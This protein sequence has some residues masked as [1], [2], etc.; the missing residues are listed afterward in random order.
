MLS[1]ALALPAAIGLGLAIIS[2]AAWLAW[3]S[4]TGMT[5]AAV[6]TVLAGASAVGA[7]IVW[8]KHAVPMERPGRFEIGA[9]A[10]AA[11]ATGLAFWS[12]PWLNPSADSFYHMAAARSLLLEGRALP[13]DIFFGVAVPYPDPTSGSLH[14]V[15]AWLSLAGGMVPAWVALCLLGAALT[16]LSFAAF[17]REVTLSVPAALIATGLYLLIGLNLDMRNAGYPAA[18]GLDLTWLTL[19]FLLRFARSDARHRPD[20]AVVCLLG[21]TSGSVYSGVSL[22]LLV[23][24]VGTLGIA[25]VVAV[26]SR[27]LSSIR[28]LAIACLALMIAVVPVL[29]IRALPTLPSP[30]PGTILA[31][32]AVLLKVDAFHGYPFVHPSFWF[33]GLITMTTIGT[34]CL[35]GRARR[36]LLDGD[37]GA[38]LI[39][40]GLLFVPAGAITPLVADTS[41]GLYFFA[42]IALLL[43]ALVFVTVGWE[44]SAIF[45]LVATIRRRS[46]TTPAA[47][48][49]AAALL[50]VSASVFAISRDL[51]GGALARY[52]GNGRLSITSSRQEDLTAQWADRLKALDTAGP[53]TILADVESSYELAG[54][55]GRRIVGVAYGHTPYQDL[56]RDGTL[57]PRDVADALKPAADP[58]ALL[59]VLVRYRVTFVMVDVDRLGPTASDWIA[60]QKA[61][62]AVAG[63]R[64]WELYRFDSGRLDQALDIPLK[65]GAGIFP[66]RV[67]AGRAIFARVAS[68]GEAGV[69]H[70][71]AVG[72]TSGARYQTQF[73][74]SGDAGATT[75]AALLVPDSVPVDRY[76]I[77]VILPGGAAIPDGEVAVG[78]AYEAE[79][80]SGVVWGPGFPR[81]RGW[82]AVVNPAYEGGEAAHETQAGSVASRPLTDPPG[83]YCLSVVVAGNGAAN[84]VDVG[85]GGT[86]LTATWPGESSGI[87]DLEIATRVG[88]A[89]RQLAYWV[90]AGAPA[91]AIV[92]RITLYPPASSRGCGPAVSP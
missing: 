74:L 90:P 54:L 73:A 40:G 58:S 51:P 44:L 2:V 43:G 34:I 63:G 16:A 92:D 88:S 71:T 5:G 12:G 59:S 9:G 83:D 23:L 8:R 24:V 25:A 7:R 60:G 46:V 68:T 18:I 72:L 80:F 65:D 56:A 15:L 33:G 70:V 6:L 87:L 55:T 19:A 64:G 39:W 4:D 11:V 14:L 32:H 1:P 3:L 78:H 22:L 76:T 30:G 27:R 61:L 28:R 81:L 37:P 52:A 79:Y 17:A 36:R 21:F 85:L 31:T 53:G 42:R 10:L 49:L 35:L 91:G 86:I 67:I 29:A 50:L 62:T 89:S 38:A 26:T 77:T 82:E 57:R 69:A 47:L 20:L 84:T 66:S 13:Q 45:G 75:T 48:R 41:L